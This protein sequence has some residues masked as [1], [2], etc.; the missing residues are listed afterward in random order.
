MVGAVRFELTTSCTPSK[1]AYQATL[2]PEPLNSLLCLKLHLRQVHLEK[3]SFKI[4][5]SPTVDLSS[6]APYRNRYHIYLDRMNKIEFEIG[7]QK[8]R[9]TVLHIFCV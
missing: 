4:E 1:R 5:R 7:N 2:R 8:R 3:P 9:T 6:V